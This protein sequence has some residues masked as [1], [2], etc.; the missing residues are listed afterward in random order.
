MTLLIIFLYFAAIFVASW[1][2]VEIDKVNAKKARDERAYE[3]RYKFIQSLMTEVTSY[4]ARIISDQLEYLKAER[5][6]N[7]EKTQTLSDEFERKFEKVKTMK[8][9][10]KDE[11]H[12]HYWIDDDVLY[13]TYRTLRGVRYR[14]VLE[15]F[16]MPNCE[17][18]TE[19]MMV[20]IE[21]Q[22]L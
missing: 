12:D 19:D 22:Y 2:V 9:I 8:E 17:K 16:G 15:V 13:E 7:K 14:P 6:K 10:V 4:H 18:C 5:H 1:A 21:K 20:Y 3:D 11:K